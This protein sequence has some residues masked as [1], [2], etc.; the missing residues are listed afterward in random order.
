MPAESKESPRISS[1]EFARESEQMG[2]YRR[3]SDE[4]EKKL[5]ESEAFTNWHEE[6]LKRLR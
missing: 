6:N 2:E 4:L 3:I 5:K 1:E